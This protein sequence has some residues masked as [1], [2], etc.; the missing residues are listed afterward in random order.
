MG[1][2]VG[3]AAAL[4]TRYSL[5]PHGVYTKRLE[6]LQTALMDADCFLPARERTVG[7]LCRRS[8][9]VDKKGV[10]VAYGDTLKNGQD[11]PNIHYG[12]TTCG[13]SLPNGEGVEYRF[14][15]PTAVES[16]HLTFDSDLDRAT[17]P[18]DKCEQDHATRANIR[19]DSP[20]F[21]LPLT[22][23]KAFRLEADTTDGIV[24]LLDVTHNAARAYHVP[25]A[26]NDVTAL[27]LIPLENYGR[28]EGT[29]VF[30]FDF[31]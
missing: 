16:V 6:E 19:L 10:P 12:T 27:R 29:R 20:Q 25:V 2:A 9:L 3:T 14:H 7:N 15:T 17:L 11:R 30:S 8:V 18:G 22:L 28:T 13:L 4:A 1:Q 23:C 5:T 26:R 24:T 31:R 21:H